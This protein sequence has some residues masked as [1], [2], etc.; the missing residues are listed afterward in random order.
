MIAIARLAGLDGMSPI[1]GVR[2]D[3]GADR[4]GPYA[5]VQNVLVSDELPR[6]WQPAVEHHLQEGLLASAEVATA[7]GVARHTSMLLRAI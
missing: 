3:R 5:A 4:G 2:G 6:G 1:W 7:S